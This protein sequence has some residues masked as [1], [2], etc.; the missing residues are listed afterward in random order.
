MRKLTTII[1]ILLISSSYSYSQIQAPNQVNVKMSQ[2]D[3]TGWRVLLPELSEKEVENA[4]KKAMKDLGA[5][6]DKVKKSDDKISEG[7]N[8]PSVSPSPIN[9]YVQFQE[10]KKGTYIITFVDMGG[11]TFLT[12]ANNPESSKAWE[13]YIT[14]F[15]RKTVVDV[16]KS[17]LEDSEKDLKGKE[18]DLKKLKK[19]KEDY[20]K[21]IKNAEETIKQRRKDIEQ[22][23][24]DQGTKE[25]EIEEQ[26]KAVEEIKKKIGKF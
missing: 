22:N 19:N 3:Q 8:M 24:K 1:I 6:F 26:K 17:R 16:L 2:G 21:D 12:A 20:E 14:S 25:Q 4:W 15:A 5:K 13:E 11:G 18:K 7:A 9:I 10:D 23:A